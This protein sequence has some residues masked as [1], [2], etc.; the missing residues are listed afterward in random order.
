MFSDMFTNFI[1]LFSINR[2][3]LG[4]WICPFVNQPKTIYMLFKSDAKAAHVVF[5]K[6]DFSSLPSPHG[7]NSA[8]VKQSL[9]Q[10]RCP[11]PMQ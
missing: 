6:I 3:I 1:F 10:L 11:L 8:S 5:Q 2:D 4:D 7:N 9:V